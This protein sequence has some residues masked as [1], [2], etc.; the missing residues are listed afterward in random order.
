M[1]NKFFEI[2]YFNFL[3]KTELNKINYTM[4]Y[5]CYKKNKNK[6]FIL[7]I[8]ITIKSLFLLKNFYFKNKKISLFLITFFN[9]IQ[10]KEI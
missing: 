10:K 6:F 3:T 9:L 7:L 1:S 2:S 4:L 8:I 5:Q